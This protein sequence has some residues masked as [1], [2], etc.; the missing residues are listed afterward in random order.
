M[1]I[2]R[3]FAIAGVGNVGKFIA[4]ELVNQ[5]AAGK[6]DEVVLLTRE[7]SHNQVVSTLRESGAKV[8][9]VN[10]DSIDSLSSALSGIEVVVSVLGYAGIG[11]PQLNL[12]EA[13]KIANVSLFIASEFGIPQRAGIPLGDEI[14]KRLGPVPMTAF[15]TGAFSDI[16]FK[17]A[18]YGGL[19]LSKGDALVPG[20]GTRAVSFTTRRDAGRYVAYVLTSL[21]RSNINGR[22]FRIEGQRACLN[23][24]I[25]EYERRSGKTIKVTYLPT[26]NLEKAV[27]ENEND[28]LS[29][30]RL[31]W[32]T[33]K[34]VVGSEVE[35]DNHEFPDWNPTEV[36]DVLLS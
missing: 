32:A 31:L 15:Y 9:V 14:T 24:I 19:I 6:A 18:D 12:A 3:K 34:G 17:L 5:L 8:A 27:A 1:S 21:P 10:Y 28:I 2:Y 25:S 7:G 16:L 35:V 29:G 33:G 20:D 30:I 23:D 11:T 36:I 13:A 4:E 26:E 22:K